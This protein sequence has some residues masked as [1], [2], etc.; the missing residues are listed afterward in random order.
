MLTLLALLA[1][2]Q[3]KAD[4]DLEAFKKEALKKEAEGTYNKIDW[5]KDAKTALEKARPDA[6]PVLVVII[7]GQMG[8]KGA[9]EC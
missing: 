8:K 9:A 2:C 4:P 7:V 3:S 5:Q 1:C 6:K